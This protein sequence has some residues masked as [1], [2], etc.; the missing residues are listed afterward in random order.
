MS[1]TPAA[2]TIK[3]WLIVRADGECRLANVG[4]RRVVLR[5]DEVAFPIVIQIPGTWGRFYAD[6]EIHLSMGYPPRPSVQAGKGVKG[7]Q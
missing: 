2:K 6:E 7:G 5:A 1:T 3:K 4:S